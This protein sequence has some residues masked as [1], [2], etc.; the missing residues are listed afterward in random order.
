M[1]CMYGKNS[2]FQHYE[3][4]ASNIENGFNT[5]ESDAIDIVILGEKIISINKDRLDGDGHL[6]N[7]WNL[8]EI[9]AILDAIKGTWQVDKFVGFVYSSIYYPD[10][11]DHN[12]NLDDAIKDTLYGVYE[13]KV[14]NAKNNIP[15]IYFSIKQFRSKNT[16]DSYIYTNDN[17]ASPIDIILSMDKSSNN[18]PAFVD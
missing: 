3:S 13:K 10:L 17:Y 6:N 2:E 18:Y 16:N 5:N 8:N 4:F 14:Q 7:R 9:D 1:I 12:D 11:F 15:Q